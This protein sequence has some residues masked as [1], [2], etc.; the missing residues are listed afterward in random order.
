[1]AYF[2]HFLW[3]KLLAVNLFKRLAASA[4]TIMLMMMDLCLPFVFSQLLFIFT[5]FCPSL[6][7]AWPRSPDFGPLSA[8]I[9][10]KVKSEE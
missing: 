1:M 9:G 10:S 8:V 5:F 2:L 4:I 3:P 7:L 6:G